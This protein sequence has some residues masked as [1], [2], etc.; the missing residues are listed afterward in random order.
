MP[1]GHGKLLGRY[2]SSSSCHRLQLLGVQ[3]NTG[4]GVKP[5]DTDQD[6]DDQDQ[7]DDRND[8]DDDDKDDDDDDDDDN[9]TYSDSYAML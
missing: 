4:C 9:D 7:N 6:E 3:Q 5:L 8:D 2:L 1:V